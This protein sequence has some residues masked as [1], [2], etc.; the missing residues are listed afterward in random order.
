MKQ[1]ETVDRNDHITA[2]VGGVVSLRGACAESCP[3]IWLNDT[4]RAAL[5]DRETAN[6][7]SGLNPERYIGW[8]NFTAEC[9]EQGIRALCGSGV[10]L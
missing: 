4:E 1:P 2:A 9:V 8:Y 3:M 6:I 5:R 7:A 10:L